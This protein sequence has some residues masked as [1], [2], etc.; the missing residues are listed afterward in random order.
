[1]NPTGYEI[2]RFGERAIYSDVP[3]SEL[4]ATFALLR[5]AAGLQGRSPLENAAAE[6]KTEEAEENLGSLP[7]VRPSASRS[8]AP[9]P[10]SERQSRERSRSPAR[11]SKHTAGDS[12]AAPSEKA[13][14]S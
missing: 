2:G 11:P 9:R 3:P 10:V 8:S 14:P 6:V 13:Q 4:S 5:K 7:L 12:A 1:M